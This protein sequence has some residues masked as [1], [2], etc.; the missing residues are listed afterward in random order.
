M[1][2]LYDI[3]FGKRIPDDQD[4][5]AEQVDPRVDGSLWELVKQHM[6]PVWSGDSGGYVPLD[7]GPGLSGYH[8]DTAANPYARNSFPVSQ[9]GFGRDFRADAAS[10]GDQ[11]SP[12]SD[13]SLGQL[14]PEWLK[15]RNV[16]WG[17]ESIPP[18]FTEENPLVPDSSQG[19]EGLGRDWQKPID[20]GTGSQTDKTEAGSGD[21]D[22]ATK[23]DNRSSFGL[24]KPIQQGRE[25][26]YDS[27][28]GLDI[29]AP[30]GTPVLAAANGKVVYAE[31]GH[32]S[33]QRRDRVTGADID[34]PYSILVELDNPVTFKDGRKANYIWYTHLSKLQ[35]EK[36]D[37]SENSVPIKQGDVIGYSG[38]ANDSPHL[39]FGVLTNRSQE[40]GEYFTPAEIREMLGIAKTQQW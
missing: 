38:T 4:T 27:D 37:G 7:S 11:T 3:L 6:A 13:D 24:T 1:S 5:S 36:A 32:T 35:V 29:S 14:V 23:E 12:M 21:L 8:G 39:H 9:T 33:W 40:E 22:T 34:T 16:G 19:S 18:L 26:G 17:I 15:S 25:A 28:T 2:T 20:A 10:S 30:V 31:K